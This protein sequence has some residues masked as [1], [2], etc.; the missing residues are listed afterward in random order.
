MEVS[1]QRLVSSVLPSEKVGHCPLSKKVSRQQSWSETFLKRKSFASAE[2]RSMVLGCTVH[3]LVTIVTELSQFNNIVCRLNRVNVSLFQ[4][5]H[6]SLM[7]FVVSPPGCGQ[8]VTD[9]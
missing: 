7:D 9:F 2:N 6:M 8:S 1:T 3:R 5:N 4:C